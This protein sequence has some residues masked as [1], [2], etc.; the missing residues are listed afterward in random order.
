LQR[1][2]KDFAKLFGHCPNFEQTL[3]A[4]LVIVSFTKALA[5]V[6]VFDQRPTPAVET[7]L[8]PAAKDM[9]QLRV[10]AVQLQSDWK[11]KEKTISQ[12]PALVALAASQGADLIVLPEMTPGIRVRLCASCKGLFLV[13]VPCM[14]QDF[15]TTF[16][17]INQR[18]RPCRF[19]R[20]PELNPN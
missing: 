2:C 12:I 6:K 15:P 20:H 1:L 4:T 8:S 14:P 11:D 18:K 7:T 5:L 9:V 10:A 16:K 3:Q 17:K 13:C 19:L